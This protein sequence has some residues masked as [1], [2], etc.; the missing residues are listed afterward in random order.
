MSLKL[1]ISGIFFGFSFGAVSQKSH[2]VGEY[3]EG[4][5]IYYVYQD[6]SGHEH[7]L[8][9]SLKNVGR[10]AIWGPKD[11]EVQ[12]CT[13]TWNG[14]SNTEAILMATKD[15]TTAAGLCNGYLSEGYDDW[16]LPAIFELSII[17]THLFA[18][19]KALA[20]IDGADSIEMNLY[21]SSTQSNAA[22]AWFYSFFDFKPTNYF[23]KTSRTLVRAV[24]SF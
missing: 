20:D 22:S 13:S 21:W 14:Q 6:S 23:D 4:G 1:L 18:V 19:E 12:N 10:E 11:L 17:N 9:V 2:F 5:I 16:Y 15:T 8:V 3:A 24:R 7:G